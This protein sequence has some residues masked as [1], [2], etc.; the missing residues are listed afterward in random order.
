MQL[1][2]HKHATAWVGSQAG[3]YYTQ[4]QMLIMH[5]RQQADAQ[6]NEGKNAEERMHPIVFYIKCYIHPSRAV[7]ELLGSVLTPSLLGPSLL[8]DQ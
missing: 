3:A 7:F 5:H 6:H 1:F 2:R 8:I 4:E